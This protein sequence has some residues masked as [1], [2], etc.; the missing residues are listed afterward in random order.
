MGTLLESRLGFDYDRWRALQPATRRVVIFACLRKRVYAFGDAV[1]VERRMRA[2]GEIV[3]KYRCP[4]CAPNYHVGHIPDMRAV[5]ALAHAIRDMHGN[6]PAK[7]ASTAV[8][9]A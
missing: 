2:R 5:A 1:T 9:V 6:L 4:F 7:R 3:R 8:V